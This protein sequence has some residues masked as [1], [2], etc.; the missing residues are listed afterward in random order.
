[1]FRDAMTGPR[2]RPMLWWARDDKASGWESFPRGSG[3]AFMSGNTGYVFWHLFWHCSLMGA[4]RL[5]LSG[6]D[7]FCEAIRM[8]AV[9]DRTRCVLDRLGWPCGRG[10]TRIVLPTFRR[11]KTAIP[12][13]ARCEGSRLLQRLILTCA[14]TVHIRTADNTLATARSQTSFSSKRPLPANACA[15]AASTPCVELTGHD[16]PLGTVSEGARAHA[17]RS[18]HGHHH[19]SFVLGGSS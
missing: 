10:H 1:M 3:D 19:I 7:R 18:H 13:S 6:S 4:M 15:C 11:R 9:E 17:S 2:W 14:R 12:V 8:A 5:G 16:L